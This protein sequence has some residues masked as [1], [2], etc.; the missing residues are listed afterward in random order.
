MMVPFFWLLSSSFKLPQEIF[1]T[2]PKFIPS[3]LRWENY[4]EVLVDQP[5]PRLVR[6]TLV[7]SRSRPR[8]A[9]C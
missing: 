5:F 4:Y 2:P 8:S 6:N 3:T 1:V 9:R 7:V